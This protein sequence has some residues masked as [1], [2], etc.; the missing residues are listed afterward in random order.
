MRTPPRL[1]GEIQQ[2]EDVGDRCVGDIWSRVHGSDAMG[3]LHS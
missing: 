1:K 2:V 3:L